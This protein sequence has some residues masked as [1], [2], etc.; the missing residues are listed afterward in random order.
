MVLTGQALEDK[1]TDRPSHQCGNGSDDKRS[2]QSVGVPMQHIRAPIDLYGGLDVHQRLGA[3]EDREAD[4]SAT[5]G[6][7][8]G[9]WSEMKWCERH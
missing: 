7:E 5:D 1:Q 8:R 2:C 3:C 4:V 6:F 9:A